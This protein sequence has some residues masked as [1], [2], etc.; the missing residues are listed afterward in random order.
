[1]QKNKITTRIVRIGLMASISIILI[2][3]IRF[4][5]FP[6]VSFLEYTPS[7]A[8][9][10]FATLNFGTIE[11]L[12]LAIIVSIIQGITVSAK[13]GFYGILMHF[14][15]TSSIVLATGL[16]YKFLNKTTTNTIISLTLGAIA[17]TFIMIIANLIITPIYTGMP[18]AAIK[19]IL[20]FVIAFNLVKAAINAAITFIM[21]K[22]IKIKQ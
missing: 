18:V 1:M 7:D 4:P 8:T 16:T 3:L 2:Y 6:A 5:L 15:A 14:I 13:S 12:F 9:I 10:L 20:P 21:F 22:T 11:G 19:Q 17:M